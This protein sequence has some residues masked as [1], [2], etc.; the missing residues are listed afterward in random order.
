MSEM[1]RQLNAFS[2]RAAGRKTLLP[3]AP[4]FRNGEKK[5]AATPRKI[6]NIAILGSTGS[7]GENT[8]K[9][10]RAHPGRFRIRVLAAR[11]SV[12]ALYRQAKEFRPEL[13]CVFEKDCALEL[14]KK[15][16][17][18]GIRVAAGMEGLSEAA[19]HPEVD[20][21]IFALVGAA[22]LVPLFEAI[23][24]SKSVAVAN[25]EP[26]V[27]AGELLM[28]ET[29]RCGVSL[30]PIDSEHSGLWQCLEGYDKKSIRRLVLTSSGG[31]FRTFRGD[32]S[33]ITVRQALN[34][35]KWKMGPKITI[36]SATLM[37]KGL[38]VIEASNLFGMPAD[39][40]DV[41][42]HP[43]AIIHAL[44]EF[45]DGSHL[46]HLA[47]TDMRLPIQYALSYP[48]R[49]DNHLPSLDLAKLGKFHFEKP[50]RRRFPCLEL[51]YEAGRQRGTM[52]CVLNAANEVAVE[53]FLNGKIAFTSIPKT[54]RKVMKRH[55]VLSQPTLS[56]L[57][58]TDAW[59]REQTGGIL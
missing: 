12:D 10:V 57:L 24:A 39:R 42:I 23:R 33:R 17:P 40:V 28:A 11:R 53:A 14:R 15:L 52:P 44:I 55:D 48:E 20:E 38:E 37:N 27:V 47:I 4:G 18:M 16:K 49:M 56:Q 3:P 26:L 21:V 13:V 54:I 7:I 6:K 46:A 36:D 35:P 58:E 2:S 9:I 8:L 25:K 59:A 5:D 32:L 34:H 19:V 43:E 51:G 50:A 30:F 41:L 45:S 29:R 31:P 1:V 22:G